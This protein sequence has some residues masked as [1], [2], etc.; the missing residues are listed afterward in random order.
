MAAA[1][2]V[3]EWIFTRPVHFVVSQPTLQRVFNYE[4]TYNAFDTPEPYLDSPVG[5][6]GRA[7]NPAAQVRRCRP[8]PRTDRRAARTSRVAY[9]RHD[10]HYRRARAAGYRA[11]SAYKLIELDDRFRMLRAGDRVADLGAWPGAWLQVA[12]E[13]VG[14]AGAWSAS[15]CPPSTPLGAPHVAVLVGDVRDPDAIAARRG[16][17]RRPRRAWCCRTW[18]RS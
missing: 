16:S 8:G 10:A 7:S 12:A 1:G 14:P 13:R 11:R 5:Y 6:R 9:E 3:L 18:R 2:F 15:I 4:P 17:A